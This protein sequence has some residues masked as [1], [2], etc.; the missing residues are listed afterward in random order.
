MPLDFFGKT[1]LPNTIPFDMENIIVGLRNLNSQE[2]CLKEVYKVLSEKYRGF[3]I[4]TYLRI[5]GVFR[6]D[7]QF[8]WRQSGFMHCTNINYLFRVL[9]VKS[10]KFNEDD[11]RIRWTMIWCIS[12]HQYLQVRLNDKWI[13]VDVW[14]KSYGV[15]FGDH[16]YGFH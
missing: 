3:R 15:E 13:D 8:L 16:S 7:V 6:K 5:L 12:P 9:L 10:G 14:G 2:E 1:K 11:V 4:I